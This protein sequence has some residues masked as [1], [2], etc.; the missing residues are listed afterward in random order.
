VIPEP[1]KEALIIRRVRL[2]ANAANSLSAL[3][4]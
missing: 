3:R 2:F 1:I 4:P